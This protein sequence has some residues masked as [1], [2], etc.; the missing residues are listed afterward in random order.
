M[1]NLNLDNYYLSSLYEKSLNKDKKKVLG[2]YYTPRFIINYMVKSILKNH[3]FK[4]KPYIK[5]L[6]LSCGCGNFLLEVYDFL[7]E[8]FKELKKDLN[9]ESIHNHIVKNCIYGVDIDE[10]AINI[11][12]NS[13][14]N[15]SLE[16]DFN[17]FNIYCLD[18]LNPNNIDIKLKEMFFVKKFDYII[19]NPPYIGHKNLSLDYKKFLVKNYSDVYKDKSDIYFCFYKRI[20][21]MLKENGIASIITPRYFLESQSGELL[22]HYISNNIKI[23]EVI[24]FNGFSVFKSANIASCI[25]TMEKNNF[26]NSSFNFYRFNNSCKLNHIENIE[27]IKDDISFFTKIHI[28]QDD[29]KKNW[30]IDK[31]ENVRLYNT[32]EQSCKYKLKDIC[33]SFQGVITGCDKAFVVNETDIKSDYIE[34]NLLKNWVKNKN[35]NKYYIQKNNLKLIYSDEITC[36]SDYV[37]SINHIKKYKD[38]LENRRECKK[39]I[40]KWYQLQWGRDK[41]MFEREKIMCPYKSSENKFAIDKNN[42]FCSADVYSF[43]IKKNYEDKFSYEYL[44]GL[45]NSSV[46]DKYFKVFAKKMGKNL[47]DY[48]PNKVMEISI[49][50]DKN[51]FNIENI[52]KLIIKLSNFDCKFNKE[53]DYLQKR[54]DILIKESLNINSLNK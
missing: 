48:Y 20:I 39:N 9:I 32:I 19:G 41:S 21:D 42:S 14:K 8:K 22:R 7:Y 30:I 27:S 24:D 40:R 46:Y 38:K 29:M 45:L 5:I 53:I 12:K 31:K 35:I 10:N 37:Y 6:D 34:K 49:F 13:L 25:F 1:E 3:D 11:L 15:K 47:Y 16:S 2:I 43:C 52:A 44:V 23:K 51:Y 33:I 4:N 17:D 18:S 50:K 28:N 36:E 54:I 26:K